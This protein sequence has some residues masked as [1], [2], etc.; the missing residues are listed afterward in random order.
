MHDRVRSACRTRRTSGVTGSGSVPGFLSDA[1]RPDHPAWAET[2]RSPTHLIVI[3]PVRRTDGTADRLF[4]RLD[5]ESGSIRLRSHGGQERVA[6]PLLMTGGIGLT[7]ARSAAAQGEVGDQASGA[8]LADAF[9][10][11]GAISH[12]LPNA[13]SSCAGP[14]GLGAARR[15]REGIAFEVEPGR[16]RLRCGESISL[17]GTPSPAALRKRRDAPSIDEGAVNAGTPSRPRARQSPTDDIPRQTSPEN[18]A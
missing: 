15:R 4:P 12:D 9:A 2:A 14:H 1:W 3:P 17:P 11:S 8:S 6:A 10:R 18:N 5:R 16:Q 13:P 7:A